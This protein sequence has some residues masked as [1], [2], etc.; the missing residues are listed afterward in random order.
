M[1]S[2][3]LI[4]SPL[5]KNGG[6]L[7]MLEDAVHHMEKLFQQLHNQ[8]IFAAKREGSSNLNPLPECSAQSSCDELKFSPL[9]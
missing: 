7:A 6:Q 9:N 3:P 1:H 4:G 5:S 2:R 8:I